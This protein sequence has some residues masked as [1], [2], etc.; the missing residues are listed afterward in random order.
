MKTGQGGPLSKKKGKVSRKLKAPT[1]QK[2]ITDHW[3]PLP[4]KDFQLKLRPA[5][6]HY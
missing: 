1:D 5:C 6:L 3:P 4:S 2:K